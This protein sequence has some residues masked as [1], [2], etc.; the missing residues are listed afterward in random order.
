MGSLTAGLG[1]AQFAFL[2]LL[3]GYVCNCPH[4]L[5]TIVITELYSLLSGTENSQLKK[6]IGI[7]VLR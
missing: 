6:V 1:G 2:D 4:E 5:P 7:P 3:C